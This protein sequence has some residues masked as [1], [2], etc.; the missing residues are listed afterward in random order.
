MKRRVT[1]KNKKDMEQL[2]HNGSSIKNIA[3]SLNFTV[4][5]ITRQLKNILGETKFK[6]I[7]NKQQKINYLNKNE[8]EGEIII[9]HNKD[10]LKTILNKSIEEE[11]LKR[12]EFI[13][14]TPLN[15][16]IENNSQKDLSSIP[17][18]DID[19]PKPVFMIVDKRVE[20]EIRS[21]KDFPKWQFLS[22][23]DLRRKTIEIYYDMK[24]AKDFCSKDQKVIKVPNPEI[25]KIVAPIL[26]SRGISR[27]VSS[28][29]LISL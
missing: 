20:L 7:K 26:R 4:Q 13:E 25:F 23:E 8:S 11:Y 27:I 22:Q 14:I 15:C 18:S 9:K 28:D 3:T 1:A 19:F 5:T 24:I 12:D 21:L 6:L 10:N 29:K 17:I 2:F 16:D